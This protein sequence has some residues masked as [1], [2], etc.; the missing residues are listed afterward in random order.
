MQ[1][2]LAVVLLLTLVGCD[3]LKSLAS[4]DAGSSASA[5]PDSTS[6]TTTAPDDT[7]AAASTASA[8][9]P[10]GFKVGEKVQG[11]WTDG[12]WYNG[13]IT[14]VNADG[15]YNIKYNDEDI[16]NHL[17]ADRV[18]LPKA[19]SGGGGTTTNAGGGG[20]SNANAPCPG[21]GIT[22]RCGGTC[23]NIQEDNNNCGDCGNRCP[24]GKHCDGHMSCRDAN[25]EL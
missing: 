6:A 7:A 19:A 2:Y 21:P 3:K 8:A 5:D 22:R 1:R 9:A 17:H 4:A 10:V 18:R 24:S 25:G 12:L 11:R 23:V 20:N 13:K 16:S 14:A 15:T